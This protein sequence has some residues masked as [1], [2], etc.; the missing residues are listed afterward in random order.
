MWD[1]KTLLM[2]GGREPRNGRRAALI[3]P[4]TSPSSRA[5]LRRWRCSTGKTV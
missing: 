3:R 4:R 5:S 1:F 2:P